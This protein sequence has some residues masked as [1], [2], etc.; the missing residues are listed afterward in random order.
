MTYVRHGDTN[1]KL[2]STMQKVLDISTEVLRRLPA[3]RRVSQHNL[4]R[5]VSDVYLVGLGVR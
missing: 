5:F 3:F 2:E 4:H 1:S